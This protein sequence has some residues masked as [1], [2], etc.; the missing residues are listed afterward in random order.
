MASVPTFGLKADGDALAFGVVPIGC[1]ILIVLLPG[2]VPL[3]LLGAFAACGCT[4]A[5]VARRRGYTRPRTVWFGFVSILA[6]MVW[7]ILMTPLVESFT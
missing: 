3:I 6:L 5:V 1:A 4:A 2:P 7:S